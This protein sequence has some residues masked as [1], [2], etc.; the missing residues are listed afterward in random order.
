MGLVSVAGGSGAGGF[1]GGCGAKRN[2]G[3]PTCMAAGGLV[4]G[5]PEHRPSE[6]LGVRVCQESGNSPLSAETAK[7]SVT[8][9]FFLLSLCHLEI[10][11]IQ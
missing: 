5:L 7:A 8:L 4:V 10:G 6:V 3:G 2:A 11:I 1:G 9:S